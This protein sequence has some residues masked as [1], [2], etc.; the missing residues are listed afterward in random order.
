M[1]LNVDVVLLHKKIHLLKVNSSLLSH[2]LKLPLTAKTSYKI[3]ELTLPAKNINTYRTFV[4][5]LT[6]LSPSVYTSSLAR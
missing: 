2:S 4:K 5:I 6:V 1:L 3:F